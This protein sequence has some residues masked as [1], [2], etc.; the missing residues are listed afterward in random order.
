M[1]PFIFLSIHAL[2][3][4]VYLVLP[5]ICSLYE[6]INPSVYGY[7][8]IR[9]LVY[10]HLCTYVLEY[11]FEH[12]FSISCT[13]IAFPSTLQYLY[14]HLFL[15]FYT[16]NHLFSICLYIQPSIFYLPLPSAT[17]HRCITACV[18]KVLP[19]TVGKDQFGS[20]LLCLQGALL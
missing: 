9:S 8:H 19:S 7:V 3:T 11:L 14:S 10:F 18:D 2:K 12:L 4:L 15:S 6:T 16:F 13:V 5:I 17:L 1:Y 20:L